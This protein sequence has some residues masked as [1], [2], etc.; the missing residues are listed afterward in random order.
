MSFE[1]IKYGTDNA[2]REIKHKGMYVNFNIYDVDGVYLHPAGKTL[3]GPAEDAKTPELTVVGIVV[4]SLQ[5]VFMFSDET[6]AL[7]AYQLI[8]K[9]WDWWLETEAAELAEGGASC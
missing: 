2:R 9:D 3:V 7:S 6:T 4:N 8:K 1:Y 5:H